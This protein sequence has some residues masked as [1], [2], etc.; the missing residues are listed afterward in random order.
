M[1]SVTGMLGLVYIVLGTWLAA[2]GGSFYYAPAGCLLLASAVVFLRRPSAGLLVYCLFL[3]AT[4]LWTYHDVGLDG[5]QW[6]PR[7]LVFA[8]LGL[9]LAWVGAAGAVRRSVSAT[10][11]MI[12]LLLLMT[13]FGLGFRI[14]H[15]RTV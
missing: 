12:S 3:V 2:S 8:L 7:L 4:A 15:E 9:A 13:I 1:S 6:M 10:T 11:A 5:W 14:T